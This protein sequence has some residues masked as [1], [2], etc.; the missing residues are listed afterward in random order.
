[1]H[2]SMS[3]DCAEESCPVYLEA[4]A[5]HGEVYTG[6]VLGVHEWRPPVSSVPYRAALTHST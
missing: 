2:V 1:M 3:L 6:N 4:S 5:G